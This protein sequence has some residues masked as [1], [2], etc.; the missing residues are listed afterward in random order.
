MKITVL[1]LVVHFRSK[2]TLHIFLLTED[3]ESS[4]D[5]DED[6]GDDDEWDD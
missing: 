2:V 5:D 6:E 4:D 1:V 3:E